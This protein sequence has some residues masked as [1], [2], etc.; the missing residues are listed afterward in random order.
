M[1]EHAPAKRDRRRV[2]RGLGFADGREV[3]AGAVLTLADKRFDYPEARFPTWGWL[4]GRLVMIVW[5]PLPNGIR[6][7][8]M[9]KVN[10][11]EQART[12]RP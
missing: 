12:D 1:I 7:I 11:R 2:E 4:A 5:T 8:S 9:R 10:E 3:L 6:V